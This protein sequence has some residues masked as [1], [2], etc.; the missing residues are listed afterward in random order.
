MSQKYGQMHDWVE[1][2]FGKGERNKQFLLFHNVFK[3][4]L[5]LMRQ[6]E[7]P[8][9]KGLTMMTQEAFMDSED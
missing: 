6:D 3:G 9:S 1:N 4:C 7:Y 2:I 8:W 5:L